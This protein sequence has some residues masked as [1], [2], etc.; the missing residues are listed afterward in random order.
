MQSYSQNLED[1]LVNRCFRNQQSGVYVDVGAGPGNGFSV[2]KNLYLQGWS[3]LLIEPVTSYAE[4]HRVARPRDTVISVAVGSEDAEIEFLHFKDTGLSTKKLYASDQIK[5]SYSVETLIIPQF[6]LQTILDKQN[7][8]HIDLLKVDVE[9]SEIEVLLGIDFNKVQPR[10]ILIEATRPMSRV[11][12]SDEL[13]KYLIGFGYS[14]AFFDGLNDY[15]V[16]KGERQLM[17]ALDSPV[18]VFDGDYFKN[19]DDVDQNARIHEL[20]VKNLILDQ[21]LLAFL[22]DKEKL[23]LELD[24]QR[25]VIDWHQNHLYALDNSIRMRIGTFVIKFLL[26]AKPFINKLQEISRSFKKSKLFGAGKHFRVIARFLLTLRII[27]IVVTYF[28]VMR[29]RLLGFW[30][31]KSL[32][33]TLKNLIGILRALLPNKQ[34]PFD[35]GLI[36]TKAGISKSGFEGIET[37]AFETVKRDLDNLEVGPFDVGMTLSRIVIDARCVQAPGLAARGIGKHASF[38]INEVCSWAKEMDLGVSFLISPEIEIPDFLNS[39]AVMSVLPENTDATLFFHLSSMTENPITSLPILLNSNSYKIGVFYD[40]IPKH[41]PGYYLWGRSAKALYSANLSTLKLYDE[42]WAISNSVSDELRAVVHKF[43][44]GQTQVIPTGVTAKIPATQGISLD[45]ERTDILIPTGG[46][47]RKDPLTALAALVILR[48]SELIKNVVVLGHL[49]QKAIKE[50]QSLVRGTWIS[51]KLRFLGPTSFDDIAMAYSTARLTLV[52]SLDEGYSLP[53]VESMNMNVPVLGSSIPAHKEL[54]QE[55]FLFKPKSYFQAARKIQFALKTNLS[56]ESSHYLNSA[57]LLVAENLIPARLRKL[58]SHLKIDPNSR[59][60]NSIGAQNFIRVV[61]PWP[62]LKTGIADYSES[63][64]KDPAFRIVCSD[65]HEKDKLDSYNW[66]WC[67]LAKSKRLF[68]LGNNHNFHSSAMYALMKMGGNAL[69]HDTRLL[70]MWSNLFGAHSF[71][72]MRKFEPISRDDFDG[73]FMN[74]D[75][76]ATLGFAPLIPSVHRF[77]THS[78]IL[79]EHLISVGAKNVYCIPFASRMPSIA[80]YKADD[81]SGADFVVGVFGITDIKTK[82]FDLIYEVCA[83]LSK[84]FPNLRLICVGELMNDAMIFLDQDN[85]RAASWLQL[86]GRVEDSEYWELLARCNVT[87]HMRKIKRLSLSGAVMDSLAVG[88]PVICSESI[89]SEMQIPVGLPYSESLGDNCSATE[90][91][92]VI[93]KMIQRE[94]QSQPDKLMNFARSRD[95]VGYLRELK[96]ALGRL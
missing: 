8:T 29:F 13:R 42:F 26:P 2:T 25:K 30:G 86:N 37:H 93:T 40:F 28:K 67:D 92:S 3:G 33:V 5:N 56:T 57:Q 39:H 66:N 76:A 7:I 88:T 23:E 9:G 69:I 50:L 90:L 15:F 4:H 58:G 89:L 17:D 41:N 21:Q 81:V 34:L 71:E 47:A 85:R 70:D 54:L 60:T 48:E 24:R 72:Y 91:K 59:L 43:G 78:Q 49:P 11:R 45:S 20:E 68:V 14:F 94:R 1:V 10:L 61:T 6:K 73:S 35:A 79:Q 31:W 62:S 51:P 32:K 18:N 38:I 16:F 74:L 84:D 64:L 52:S 53:I 77:I 22:A 63:T 96:V 55:R 36:Q 95:Y 44:K 19:S 75:S 83:E 65:A 80:P 82:H 87:I 46:D 27:R 12:V